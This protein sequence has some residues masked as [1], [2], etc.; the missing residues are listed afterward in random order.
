M[1]DRDVKAKGN[2]SIY[3]VANL[4]ESSPRTY[5]AR[6]GRKEKLPPCG[7]QRFFRLLRGTTHW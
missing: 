6:T 1:P 7:D 5:T 3:R 4:T 2:L